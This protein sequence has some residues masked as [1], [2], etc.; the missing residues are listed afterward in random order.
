MKNMKLS[1]I[2]IRFVIVY[3]K[4]CSWNQNQ[5]MCFFYLIDQLNEA[6]IWPNGERVA[7]SKNIIYIN[8]NIFPQIPQVLL[9]SV[10]LR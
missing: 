7:K 10:F 2:K 4:I 5:W 6:Q 3:L 9:A 8:W 1:K